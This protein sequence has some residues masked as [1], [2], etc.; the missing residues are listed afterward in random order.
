MLATTSYSPTDPSLSPV[1]QPDASERGRAYGFNA[2][3]WSMGAVL[4]VVLGGAIVTYVSWR[5]IFW[6]NVPIGVAALILALRV[7]HERGERVRRR[8]DPAGMVALGLG[9]FGVL[10]A[11]DASF[12]WL[13]G[14]I[15]G[16][17]TMGIDHVL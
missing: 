2:V 13:P 1:F 11:F 15:G 3:G 5:W 17:M 6:I 14:F 10:W 8:L 4:G 7:L 9:L 12:K 16:Q